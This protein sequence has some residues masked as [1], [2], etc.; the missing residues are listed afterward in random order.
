MFLGY[1][2]HK[3]CDIKMEYNIYFVRHN[4]LI[5]YIDD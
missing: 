3:F 1:M 4:Y 2:L 5:F